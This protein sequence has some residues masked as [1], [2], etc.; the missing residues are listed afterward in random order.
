L[1]AEYTRKANTAEARGGRTARVYGAVRTT[2]NQLIR[3]FR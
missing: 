3:I 2:K 1:R